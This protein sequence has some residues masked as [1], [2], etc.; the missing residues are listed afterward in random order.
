MI[1]RLTRGRAP[2]LVL[3]AA[4]S[5]LAHWKGADAPLLDYHFHRQV[6]TAAIARNYA[7]EGRP[8]HSPRI[9]WE[10]GGDR[11]A[12]TELPLQMWL[13]GRLWAAGLGERAGRYLSIAASMLT[14]LVLFLLFDR[15][16]GREAAVW[17]SCLF[18]LMPL[19][20]YFGRTVQPEAIALLGVCLG[21]LLWDLSLEKGRPLWAWGG[22]VLC[23]FVATGLKLPYFYVFFPL[24]GLAW[25]RLGAKALSD[26]R[27]WAAGLVSSGAVLAWYKYASA[28]V[29]VVPTHSSEFLGIL[30]WKRVPYYFQFL[31]TSRFLELVTTYGGMV[32][33]LAG[34]REKLWKDREVFWL[35]WL[36]GTFL[37]LVA[38]GSYSHQHEYTSL[39][40]VP[41]VAG[42]M[43][44]GLARLRARAQ[45]ASKAS[46]PWALAGIAVLAVSVPVHAA[47]RIPHWYRQ[48]FSFVGRAAEG[49]AAVS[50]R[51][52]LFLTNCM[53][54]SVLLYYL[55]R[56]GW[57]DEL[58]SHP[59]IA[60]A[61]IEEFRAKGAVFIASEKKGLFAEDGALWKRFRKAGPPAWDD[62]SLVIFRLSQNDKMK[63]PR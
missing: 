6:N 59:A 7:R 38:L 15:E 20:V 63:A 22:A 41:P 52:D 21:L 29:Y 44:L 9:D 47:L 14:A 32:L 36:G 62:G 16:L 1:A 35:S 53:A 5:L 2:G 40:L 51:D 24:A 28:G 33:F 23:V 39:T 42:L 46:R 58:D 60:D 19:E 45:S 31:V 37:H 34:A 56:R 30:D 11:M 12:A 61:K 10:G 25:R 18:S 55:D 43:G 49:A 48:G 50:S 3:A 17:G 54:S 27:L 13:Y 26:A 4:L 57:S 8:I